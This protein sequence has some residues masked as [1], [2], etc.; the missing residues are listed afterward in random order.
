MATKIIGN[1]IRCSFCN[2]T[3]AQVRKLIAGPAGVYIC[4]ECIDICADIV[5]VGLGGG[6]VVG[7]VRPGVT[8]CYPDECMSGL[9]V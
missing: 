4:D 9:C 1:D 8:R 3:Q 6:E 5:G 7:G 2:K